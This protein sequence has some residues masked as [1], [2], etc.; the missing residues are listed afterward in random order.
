MS[1]WETPT[2]NPT[3]VSPSWTS[4]PQCPWAETVILSI[5][6]LKQ[7]FLHG[8]AFPELKNEMEDNL[9]SFPF[10]LFYEG[11]FVLALRNENMEI[12]QNRHVPCKT[13]GGN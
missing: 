2:A 11:V 4:F 13:N 12:N 6:L 1:A 7:I 9:L 5:L 10:I 3:R 8:M